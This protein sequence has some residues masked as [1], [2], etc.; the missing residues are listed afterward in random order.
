MPRRCAGECGRLG[1]SVPCNGILPWGSAAAHGKSMRLGNRDSGLGFRVIVQNSDFCRCDMALSE[2]AKRTPNRQN[3]EP[4][5]P[6][7]EHATH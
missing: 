3:P 4:R 5:V 1:G 7:P 2:P 6:S